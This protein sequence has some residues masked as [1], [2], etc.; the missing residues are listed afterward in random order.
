MTRVK[1][2]EQVV[3]MMRIVRGVA[4]RNHDSRAA[5]AMCLAIAVGVCGLSTESP[6]PGMM[7]RLRRRLPQVSASCWG[8]APSGFHGASPDRSI[9]NDARAQRP[10]CA[11][12]A[13][14]A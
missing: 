9:L 13:Y 1:M 3:L 14:C 10:C 5:L 6:V 11:R 2:N 4:I 7:M 12:A 8:H